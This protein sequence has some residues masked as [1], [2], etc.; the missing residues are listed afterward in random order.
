MNIMGDTKKIR[1]RLVLQEIAVDE[2]WIRRVGN[3]N[4]TSGKIALPH[5]LIGKEV[6][7][8]LKPEGKRGVLN[9]V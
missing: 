2:I 3:N 5:R 1:A 7:V 6:Y 9:N 4:A 8:I